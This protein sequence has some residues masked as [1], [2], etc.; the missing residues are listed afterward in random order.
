MIDARGCP[1]ANR[2]AD[3]SVLVA[4]GATLTNTAEVYSSGRW[5]QAA[6]MVIDRSCQAGATL[7]SG[8]VVIFGGEHLPSYASEAY[9]PATG[10]WEV[11][12]DIEVVSGPLTALLGGGAFVAGGLTEYTTVNRFAYIYSLSTDRW[13]TGPSLNTGRRGHTQTLLSGGQVLIAGGATN[14]TGP[15]SVVASAELYTP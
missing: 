6:H 2:L 15:L 13:T 8:D 9:A 7:T 12:H 14:P 4:G 3:G 10:A 1:S 11:T 5:S